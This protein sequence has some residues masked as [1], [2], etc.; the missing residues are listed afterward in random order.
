MEWWL[1]WIVS[2]Y[3]AGNLVF[4]LDSTE[5]DDKAASFIQFGELLDGIGDVFDFS[6]LLWIGCA[7]DL[8]NH[9]CIGVP[10]LS[11]LDFISASTTWLRADNGG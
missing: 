5:S 4:N 3:E 10:I 8:W 1:D 7:H 2:K 9:V 6:D 11:L